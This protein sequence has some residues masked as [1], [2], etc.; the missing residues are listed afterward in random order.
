MIKKFNNFLNKDIRWKIKI[1]SKKLKINFYPKLFSFKG[2]KGYYEK[3]ILNL[4]LI[5]KFYKKKKLVKKNIFINIDNKNNNK[6][7]CLVSSPGSGSNYI[8]CLFSSYFE[9][10][11]K[12]GNGIPK[13]SNIHNKFIFAASPILSADLWNSV[14]LDTNQIFDNDNFNRFI[15]IEDFHKKKNIFFKISF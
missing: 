7:N 10:Y 11:Y 2:L 8:R 3:I 13:F 15:S 9:I 6:I 12:I 5:D 1:L 4:I 14:N